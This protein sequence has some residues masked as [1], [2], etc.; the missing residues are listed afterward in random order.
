MNIVWS[1]NIVGINMMLIL[2]IIVVKYHIR[3]NIM[4]YVRCVSY[5]QFLFFG[6]ILFGYYDGNIILMNLTS[7]FYEEL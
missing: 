5:T 1:M 3:S 2:L 4:K 7:N 6:F